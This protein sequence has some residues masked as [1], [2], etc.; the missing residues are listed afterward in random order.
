M[1]KHTNKYLFLL[2]ALIPAS[3]VFSSASSVF[4]YQFEMDYDQSEDGTKNQVV[5]KSSWKNIVKNAVDKF[6]EVLKKGPNKKSGSKRYWES[7]IKV[8]VPDD[9][10]FYIKSNQQSVIP[11]VSMSKDDYTGQDDMYYMTLKSKKKI[12]KP[13]KLT[14]ELIP[15]DS[16]GRKITQTFTIKP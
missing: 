1:K 5:S 12:T 3:S 15:N 13:V 4:S 10:W 2:L 9:H 6:K 7:K 14:I 8:Y 11:S 16:G